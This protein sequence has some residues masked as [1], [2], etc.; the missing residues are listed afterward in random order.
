MGAA[1]FTITGQDVHGKHRIVK[2]DLVPS[3]SYATGGD[4]LDL[5]AEVGLSQVDSMLV[6]ENAQGASLDL[7]VTDPTAP[8]VKVYTSADT[9]AAASSDN[10][11]LTFPV[12]L[13]GS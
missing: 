1:T 4:S 5:A 13:F 12:W 3:G 10:D 9:Q 7:D 2:G 8:K 11:G 6:A